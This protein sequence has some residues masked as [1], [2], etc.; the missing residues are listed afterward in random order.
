MWRA[1]SRRT[2]RTASSRRATRT[3]SS[4]SASR[5]HIK[6]YNYGTKQY[7][8]APGYDV[9]VYKAIA[10]D[11][12]DNIPSIAPGYGPKK[13]MKLVEAIASGAFDVDHLP[14]EQHEIYER[15]LKLVRFFVPEANELRKL[16]LDVGHFDPA[17]CMIDFLM[18]DMPSLAEEPQYSKF[19]ATMG[20]LS[21]AKL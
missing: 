16:Q 21:Q 14:Q 19:C 9:L 2:G 10:G 3:S 12:S 4:C 17:A 7:V 18:L 8:E 6:L 5:P 13:T 11:K 1:T 15:N 20:S